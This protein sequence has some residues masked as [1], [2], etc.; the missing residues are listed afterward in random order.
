MGAFVYLCL[1]QKMRAAQANLSICCKTKTSRSIACPLRACGLEGL[2]HAT[3]VWDLRDCFLVF[4]HTHTIPLGCAYVIFPHEPRNV[5]GELEPLLTTIRW[6]N[7]RPRILSRKTSSA[8]IGR[9]VLHEDL[10]NHLIWQLLR[11]FRGFRSPPSGP[12]PLR[13][14]PLP[15]PSGYAGRSPHHVPLPSFNTSTLEQ[16]LLIPSR[17]RLPA[18][19]ISL[20]HAPPPPSGAMARQQRCCWPPMPPAVPTLPSG[21]PSSRS[22]RMLI[23]CRHH[24]C[25]SWSNLSPHARLR[26]CPR[27]PLLPLCP[28]KFSIYPSPLPPW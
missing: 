7:A 12:A 26:S 3:H 14:C 16:I 25:C 27:D 9:Q 8:P 6:A 21:E 13:A 23:P 24:L 10:Q 2:A 22:S 18:A 17:S 4:W 19:T 11:N 20:T 28:L 5:R 1:L 15:P